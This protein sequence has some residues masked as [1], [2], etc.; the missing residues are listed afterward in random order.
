MIEEEQ[1]RHN[2]F[3]PEVPP[4][5]YAERYHFAVNT[6]DDG[7]VFDLD[8]EGFA[9]PG[10]VVRGLGE[11]AQGN[12]P[13]RKLYV[14]ATDL[15]LVSEPEIKA[16]VSE[17]YAQNQELNSGDLDRLILEL[18]RI[19]AG[20]EEEASETMLD[21]ELTD[22]ELKSLIFIAGRYQSAE[23]LLDAYDEETKQIPYTAVHEAYRATLED[24]GDEGTVP[25]AGG[26][27][28]EKIF[29]L[30]NE[31]QAYDFALPRHEYYEDED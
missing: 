23:I 11:Y 17:L 4:T 6:G 25:L 16:A 28:E 27:L 10:S 24:G 5:P 8:A 9:L 21:F 3:D 14:K 13:A 26:S 31:S 22:Q 7:D 19:A 15:K 1:E 18:Q 2:R 30:W 29:D 20:E 12:G